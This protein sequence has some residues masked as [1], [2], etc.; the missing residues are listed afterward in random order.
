MNGNRWDAKQLESFVYELEQLQHKPLLAASPP[1][2]ETL[3]LAAATDAAG[4]KDL[5]ERYGQALRVLRERLHE[6]SLP[7]IGVLGQ[8]NAGKSSV[9]ASF[10][11]PVGRQ[12][13]PRGLESQY[14]THRFVYWLPQSWHNDPAIRQNVAQ[15]LAEIHGHAPEPLSDNPDEAA[16][17]YRSGE[18]HPETIPVPLLAYDPGLQTIGL[19]DCLDVQTKDTPDAPA[20][21]QPIEIN[22]RLEFVAQAA[23]VCSAFWVVWQQDTLRDRLFDA[24]LSR[25]RQVMSDVPLYLLI[26]KIRPHPSQPAAIFNDENIQAAIKKYH[27]A[28]V[29]GAFDFEIPGWRDFTPPG[30]AGMMADH[31]LP[32]FYRFSP[33]YLNAPQNVPDSE[34]LP[35]LYRELEPSQLYQQIIASHRREISAQG[36]AC[37]QAI[38]QWMDTAARNTQKAYE[39]LLR[40]CNKL[41]ADER[42]EPIQINDPQ[43]F[44]TLN[45]LILAQAPWYVRLANFFVGYVQEGIRRAREAVTSRMPLAALRKQIRQKTGVHAFTWDAQ[46]LGREIQDRRFIPQEWDTDTLSEIWNRILQHFQQHFHLKPDSDVMHQMADD[47]WRQQGETIKWK[48]LLG[49]L[50]CVVGVGGLFTAIVDGG[51]TMLAGFSMAG[52]LAAA[53]PGTAALT[54]GILGTGTAMAAFYKGLIEQNSLP[55]LAAMF[56]ICCDALGLPRQLPEVKRQVE[57]GLGH[58]RRTFQLPTIGMPSLPPVRP[59]PN[60]GYWKWTDEGRRWVDLIGCTD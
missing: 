6:A 27:I 20:R 5:T 8:L 13:L 53:L 16:V 1:R 11:S 10:L 9:V 43:F 55:A 60:C 46:S 41:F 37:Y 48:S 54:V 38:L 12:R 2:S 39:G 35:H 26:N 58:H 17:Q 47:T 59:L 56:E 34:W 36:Q 50:G 44:K 42:N 40:F 49:T 14:G 24:F 3:T 23:R 28:G 4:R 33:K 18:K 45:D 52:S 31:H 7:I 30:L 19:L 22:Q 25:I 57:F 29:Y 51:A 15:L 21:Q 32:C